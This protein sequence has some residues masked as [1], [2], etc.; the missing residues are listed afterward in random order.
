M[1]LYFIFQ[2]FHKDDLGAPASYFYKN[3]DFYNPLHREKKFTFPEGS[4]DKFTVPYRMFAKCSMGH[5]ATEALKV[6]NAAWDKF[7]DESYEKSGCLPKMI[8]TLRLFIK[9]WSGRAMDHYHYGPGPDGG[10]PRRCSVRC[11]Q[12]TAP[13]TEPEMA[14]VTDEED[15]GEVISYKA[16]Y[17][18]RIWLRSGFDMAL[19]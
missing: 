6:L 17:M 15:E 12:T 16:I 19:I 5:H 11:A 9:N 1:L 8:D 4:V 3:L 7:L 2:L 10:E 18:A 13:L 14:P